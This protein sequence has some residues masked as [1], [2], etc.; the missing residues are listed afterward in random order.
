MVH[1]PLIFLTKWREFLSATGLAE[2]KIIDDSARLHVV[3][4]S[5]VA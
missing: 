3:E 4:I 1:I 2:K 5:P